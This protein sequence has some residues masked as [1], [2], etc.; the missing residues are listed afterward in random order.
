MPS[1]IIIP[2]QHFNNQQIR[3]ATHDKFPFNTKFNFFKNQSSEKPSSTSN[4]QPTGTLL[5]K[6]LSELRC[7][8]ENTS[9]LSLTNKQTPKA[10]NVTIKILALV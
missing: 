1:N 9:E 5:T 8:L 7:S 3:H 10:R 2:P 6:K 4:L